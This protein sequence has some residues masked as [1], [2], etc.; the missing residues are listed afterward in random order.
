VSRRIWEISD[1]TGVSLDWLMYGDG[2]ELPRYRGQSRDDATLEADVAKRVSRAIRARPDQPGQPR[3]HRWGVHGGAVLAD[4][5]DRAVEEANRI[6]RWTGRHL[7]T[8]TGADTILRT[9]MH[10]RS[11]V[12]A[13]DEHLGSMFL[14]LG[15]LANDLHDQVYSDDG[16]GARYLRPGEQ[17]IN[18]TL[19]MPARAALDAIAARIEASM[20]EE[21]LRQIAPDPKSMQAALDRLRAEAA[22]TPPNASQALP[23]P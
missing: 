18:P 19:C 13:T 1:G 14:A 12:D 20:G 7:S 10:L 16:P 9:L 5:C 22:D 11:Y 3:Y 6:E 21:Y 15:N 8:A 4:A 23:T 17:I 2:G